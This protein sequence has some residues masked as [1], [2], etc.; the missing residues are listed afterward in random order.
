M[1]GRRL[2]DARLVLLASLSSWVDD[3]RVLGW[4]VSAL[5]GRLWQT[6]LQSTGFPLAIPCAVN[7]W[8]GLQPFLIALIS[9]D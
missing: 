1:W 3:A 8:N 9:A 7:I 4:I 5:W 2:R 6:M